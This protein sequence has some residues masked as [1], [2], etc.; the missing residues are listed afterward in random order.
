MSLI[1]WALMI[2]LSFSEIRHFLT[3]QYTEHMVVD[4]TIGEPIIVNLNITFHALSCYDSHLDVMNLAGENQLNVEHR[5]IKQRLD[6]NG[7][8][9]GEPG[10]EIIGEGKLTDLPPL[11]ADYCGSCFGAEDD[12]RK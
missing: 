11:P 12:I 10:Y 7:N 1:C 5:M 3:P 2:I 8:P 6:L 9:I 4:T